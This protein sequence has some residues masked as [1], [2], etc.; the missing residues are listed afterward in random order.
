M[1]QYS[2]LAIYYLYHIKLERFDEIVFSWCAKTAWI[3]QLGELEEHA[4]S[5]GEL[6]K[7]SRC[8]EMILIL[9]GASF[10]PQRLLFNFFRLRND[11]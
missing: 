4:R 6:R 5:T 11:T 1:K 10:K 9:G 2:V 7:M 8:S 3:A